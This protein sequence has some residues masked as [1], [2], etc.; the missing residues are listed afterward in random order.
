M[1]STQYLQGISRF[2]HVDEIIEFFT[3]DKP[4]DW[5]QRD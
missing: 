5:R 3:E 4:E 1:L 2:N